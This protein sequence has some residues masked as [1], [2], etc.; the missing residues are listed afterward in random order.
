M[1]WQR[2]IIDLTLLELADVAASL[3]NIVVKEKTTVGLA[4]R[5]SMPG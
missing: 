5:I 3:E 2:E 1:T 4:V